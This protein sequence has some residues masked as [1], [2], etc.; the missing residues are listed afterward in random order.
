MFPQQ[1]TLVP[2]V[3]SQL[4]VACVRPPNVAPPHVFAPPGRGLSITWK[5]GGHKVSKTKMLR[6]NGDE[7]LGFEF[8]LT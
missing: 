6:F 3:P 7:K 1:Q 4:P 2:F 8:G 5:K